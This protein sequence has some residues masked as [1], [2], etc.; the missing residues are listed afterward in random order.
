MSRESSLLKNTFIYAIGNFSS[1]ILSFIL[2]PFY[3]YYLSTSDFGYYDLILTATSMLTPII[4]FQISDGLYR[5]LLDAKGET[6]KQ[7]IISTS[8]LTAIKNI[9]FTNIIFIIIL[10]NITDLRYGY[11]IMLQINFS[12]L[13]ALWAQAARG[14]RDN[15]GYSVAGV[16]ATFVLLISNI[17]LI[18]FTNMR[19]DALIISTI[20]S[21]VII[22]G[23]LE[24]RLGL[25][26]YIK[27]FRP[28]RALRT[29][30]FKYSLP[31]IPNMIS[32]WIMNLSDRFIILHY[33]GMGAN[34]IY[35][36]ANKFPAML[37]L[38]YSIF[39]L[40]WQDCAISEYKAQ[41]ISAFYTRLYNKL[42]ILQLTIIFV[43]LSLT[44]PI[45]RFMISTT[46]SAAWIYVPFLYIG[47][48]FSNL[49]SFFGTGYMSSKETSGAFSTSIAGSAVNV[50]LNFILIKKMGIQ[51][52]S[53][54]T[55]LAFFVMWLARVW[56][57]RKYLQ[58]AVNRKI[59]VGYGLLLGLF[60]YF[61]YVD[62]FY[63]QVL[64][65][66]LAFIIFV[67]S[68]RELLIGCFKLYRQRISRW[69]A[70]CT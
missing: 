64:M 41:D 27:F 57:T 24:F 59:L 32:W 58:I 10:N 13:S 69:A 39:N 50:V 23:Y 56:Q 6:E 31:L 49:S 38:I 28:N 47:A 61:Y 37:V 46:F 62:K 68:N 18:K 25:R 29:T 60:T 19:V 7:E 35:A 34:G 12:I 22:I 30:L 11:L 66:A 8:F 1:K 26:R 14:I 45:M 36:V 70:R 3:T 54:S 52:A 43:L 55:M 5:F 16:L 53:L 33:L 42:F 21:N 4:S 40:S 44:K 65:G 63:I 48:V 51:A 67:F 20:L 17:T 2:L 15:V 9:I